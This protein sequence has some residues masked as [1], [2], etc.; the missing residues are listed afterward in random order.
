MARQDRAAA[1]PAE[2]TP[3]Y[4]PYAA[5]APLPTEDHRGEG[6]NPVYGS[7]PEAPSSCECVRAVRVGRTQ[8]KTAYEV[9]WE[10]SR[11]MRTA[12]QVQQLSYL[13]F[14]GATESVVGQADGL[15]GIVGNLSA[16]HITLEL[17]S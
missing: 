5:T 15:K 10:D 7:S 17:L 12:W 3:P 14:L 1:K 6:G 9:S 13:V 8:S 11:K 4:N 16:N 2:S